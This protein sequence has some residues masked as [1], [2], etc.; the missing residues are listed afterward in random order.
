MRNFEEFKLYRKINTVNDLISV[1]EAKYNSLVFDFD[2]KMSFIC[3]NLMFESMDYSFLE[4]IS[5]Q[6][7]LK[8]LIEYGTGIITREEFMSER[9]DI[10]TELA[11]GVEIKT[12]FVLVVLT[13][14]NDRLLK[15]A[16]CFYWK[17]FFE[18][19]LTSTDTQKDLCK[20]I[21]VAFPFHF[22]KS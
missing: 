9:L 18:E 17:Q 2:R 8:S 7:V 6:L 4:N 22:I 21:R 11:E 16:L 12:G 14:R 15:Y 13:N 5:N 10:I 19:F 20:I 1:L 3:A